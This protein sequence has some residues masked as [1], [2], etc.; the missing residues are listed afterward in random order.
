MTCVA[1]QFLVLKIRMIQKIFN[2]VSLKVV[3]VVCTKGK[4]VVS[5]E[6]KHPQNA[7]DHVVTL[8]GLNPTIDGLYPLDHSRGTNTFVLRAPAKSTCDGVLYDP[9]AGEDNVEPPR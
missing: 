5:L 3:K 1:L 4:L 6:G 2:P 8:K 9:E 7:L